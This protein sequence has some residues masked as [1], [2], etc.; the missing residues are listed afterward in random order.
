MPWLWLRK[1][2]N[3]KERKGKKGKQYSYTEVAVGVGVGDGI[4]FSCLRPTQA[5]LNK[6]YTLFLIR[7]Y[8]NIVY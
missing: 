7:L 8:G 1:K 2:K 6:M 4:D 5:I 3:K